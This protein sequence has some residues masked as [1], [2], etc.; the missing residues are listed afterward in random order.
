MNNQCRLRILIKDV[1][2]LSGSSS[3]VSVYFLSIPEFL[4]NVYGKV[5]FLHLHLFYLIKPH[6]Q[7]QKSIPFTSFIYIFTDP[8]IPQLYCVLCSAIF[9]VL[10]DLLLM[11]QYLFMN[12]IYI[13][14][15][16]KQ[17]FLCLLTHDD[18]HI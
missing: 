7:G 17:N 13:V 1:R 5:V 15:Q 10:T 2:Y 8:Y 18:N 9:N 6:T 14:S 3:S 11:V 16:Y 12:V 4:V